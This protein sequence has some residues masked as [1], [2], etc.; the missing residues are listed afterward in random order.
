MA[1]H[2]WYRQQALR[3]RQ[4]PA[5]LVDRLTHASARRNNAAMR[6]MMLN[7][8]Y[9]PIGG[10][11]SPVTRSLSEHLAAAGHEVDVVMMGY[12]KLPFLESFGRLRVFRGPALRRSPVRA[13]TVEMLSYLAAALPVALGL[14]RQRY[15]LIHAHFL[16]PTGLLALAL[17]RARHLPTVI[18]AHGSDVPGYN[19]DRFT[20]GHRLLG[21]AGR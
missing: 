21:P 18:T 3:A 12:R 10:G 19:P 2:G 6:I 20:R 16:V 11:A 5:S 13:V 15:N 7:Y 1:L 17:G 14:S 8:E 4:E 9:P